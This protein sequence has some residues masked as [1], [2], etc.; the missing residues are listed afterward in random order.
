M[1]TIR[2]LLGVTV[3]LVAEMALLI[4]AVFWHGF[5]AKAALCV[6]LFALITKVE[7]LGMTSVWLER[8]R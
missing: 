1:I 4:V 8:R 2:T 5:W 6:L 7:L 3:S